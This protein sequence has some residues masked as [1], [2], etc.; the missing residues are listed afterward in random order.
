MTDDEIVSLFRNAGYTPEQTITSLM[1][2]VGASI[3][4]IGSDVAD[5]SNDS[6]DVK[7]IVTEK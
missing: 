3:L 6:F 1:G 2:L 5:Y 4:S 7:V